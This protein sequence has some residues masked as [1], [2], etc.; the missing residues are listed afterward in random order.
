VATLAANLAVDFAYLWL[1][2]RLRDQAA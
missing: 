1:D 2:P